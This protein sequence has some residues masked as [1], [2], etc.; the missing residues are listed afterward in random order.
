MI[1]CVEIKRSAWASNL[2][3]SSEGKIMV[4]VFQRDSHLEPVP[5]KLNSDKELKGGT[6]YIAPDES[7]LL[8][9]MASNDCDDSTDLYISYRESNGKWTSPINLG[10]NINSPLSY[11]LCPKVSPNDKFLFFISR[12]NGPDFRIY[13]ADAKIIKELRPKEIK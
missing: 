13:W 5:L 4:S 8:Y 12:R 3:F 6:P 11:D 9:S 1:G 2:Y 10:A 7:Y